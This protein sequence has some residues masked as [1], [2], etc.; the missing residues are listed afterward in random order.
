MGKRM[1]A[2]RQTALGLLVWG[3]VLSGLSC[4]GDS[5]EPSTTG[6]LRIMVTTSGP[7]PDSDGYAVMVHTGCTG[8][9]QCEWSYEVEP[10]DTV[11]VADLTPGDYMVELIGPIAP[12]CAVGGQYQRT[13]EIH[14]GVQTTEA[15]SVSCVTPS[16]F[17]TLFIRTVTM[18]PGNDPDGYTVRVDDGDWQAIGGS[19]TVT[20]PGLA[21]GVHS[22][23]LGGLASN[24]ILE[25]YDQNP[26]PNP[27]Y[28]TIDA[29]P[30]AWVDFMVW[31][32]HSQPY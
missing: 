16:T 3:A 8:Y 28:V 21:P 19:A 7:F 18:G 17:S 22:V 27:K 4:G 23:L 20:V 25:A 29:Y 5:N 24:C 13:L 15:F 31:C 9:T 6:T 32:T 1:L 11:E 10:T 14:A 2:L 26:P 30:E 12:N